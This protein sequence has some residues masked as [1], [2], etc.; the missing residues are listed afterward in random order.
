MLPLKPFPLLGILL[1]D[2]FLSTASALPLEPQLI[3]SLP[4]TK[5]G[6][7]QYLSCPG[8]LPLPPYPGAPIFMTANFARS[9]IL[10]PASLSYTDEWGIREYIFTREGLCSRAGCQ[11]ISNVVVSNNFE[12]IF[13]SK[14][15]HDWYAPTCVNTC[16]CT[17]SPWLALKPVGSSAGS[18]NV[19]LELATRPGEASTNTSIA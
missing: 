1:L 4:A 19:S 8:P 3:P 14:P 15:L 10:F 9:G 16:R 13:F 7:D 18:R 12:Y 17:S 11:C 5:L 6:D 2:F